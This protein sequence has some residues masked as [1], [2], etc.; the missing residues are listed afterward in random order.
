MIIKTLIQ[1]LEFLDTSWYDRKIDFGNYSNIRDR[2]AKA[3]NVL[4]EIPE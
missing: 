2:V 1:A 4:L 3:L